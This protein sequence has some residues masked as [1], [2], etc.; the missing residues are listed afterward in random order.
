MKFPVINLKGEKVKELELS[1]SIFG[2]KWNPELVHQILTSQLANRRKPWAHAKGRGEVRGGG[3]KPWRQKG[4]GRARHGSTRSPI[5]I[6]GGKAHGPNKE[7]NYSEKVN[8]KMNRLAIL[9][10]LS[11]RIKDGEVKVIDGFNFNPPKTKTVSISLKN[12][13][14]IPKKNKKYDVLL[15]SDSNNREL[16]KISRN[17]QKSKTLNADSLNVYDLLNYKHILIEEPSIVVIGRHYRIRK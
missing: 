10:A 14:N 6:G 4:T 8:K 9:G 2:I 7:R 5:W 3:R 17:L 16:N 11:K 13:L 15:I 12:L 1:D